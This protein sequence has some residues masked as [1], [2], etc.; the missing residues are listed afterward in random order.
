MFGP[1][2]KSERSKYVGMYLTQANGKD[3]KSQGFTSARE[4]REGKFS[5]NRR[6]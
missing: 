2:D 6:R 3:A 5:Q 1:R 4:R